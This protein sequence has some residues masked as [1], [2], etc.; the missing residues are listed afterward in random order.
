MS[1]QHALS[2]PPSVTASS[3][4]SKQDLR[5]LL[6]ILMYAGIGLFF[7]PFLWGKSHHALYLQAGGALAAIVFGIAR[8]LFTEEDCWWNVN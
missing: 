4:L 7:V 8:C 5:M 1:K 3:L 2:K 6:T